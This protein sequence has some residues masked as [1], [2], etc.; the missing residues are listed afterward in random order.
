MRRLERCS[1]LPPLIWVQFPVE[2]EPTLCGWLLGH[3]VPRTLIT[4][5]DC[6]LTLGQGGGSGT[7][8]LDPRSGRPRRASRDVVAG[9]GEPV[10]CAAA[11]VDAL[12]PTRGGPE[13]E[14]LHDFGRL[15]TLGARDERHLCYWREDSVM[16]VHEE[17]VT[18][19]TP[20]VN[21]QRGGGPMIGPPPRLD[22][23]SRD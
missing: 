14:A 11:H 7:D 18:G 8:A 9:H 3:F 12:E 20:G 22:G 23:E 1:T 6:H 21:E 10:A 17:S 19:T 16:G 4:S 13:D 15:T 5:P 2:E